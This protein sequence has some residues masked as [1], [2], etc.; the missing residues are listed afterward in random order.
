[1]AAYPM[2]CSETTLAEFELLEAFQ[3]LPSLARMELIVQLAGGPTLRYLA[4]EVVVSENMA[5]RLTNEFASRFSPG[6]VYASRAAEG[7]LSQVITT[8]TFAGWKGDNP[9]EIDVNGT[10]YLSVRLQGSFDSSHPDRVVS[11][12]VAALPQSPI[13]FWKRSYEK[14]DIELRFELNFSVLSTEPSRLIVSPDCPDI[15]IFQLNAMAINHSEASK[16]LPKFLFEYYTPERWNSLLTLSLMDHLFKN[17]GDLPEEQ[18]RIDAVIQPLRQYTLLVLLGE[19]LEAISSEF[20]SSMVGLDRI[21]DLVKKQCQ[22]LY[23][24]YKTL[25]TNS[26]WQ[27]NLQQYTHALQRI[28][29]QGEL[30]IA[31]GRRSWKA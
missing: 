17:R 10:K 3:A 30:S 6:K 2:G 24:R 28:I 25:I 21:K 14:T 8:P 11:V 15:A 13:P 27:N 16:I 26:K 9:R 1:M 4:E 12:L 18:N 22:Q 20:E 31:R 19:Q 5:Q 7:L 23:P 29:S